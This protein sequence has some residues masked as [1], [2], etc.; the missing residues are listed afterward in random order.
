MIIRPKLHWLSFVFVW[1]GSVLRNI[2][3]RL[4]LNLVLSVVAVLCMPQFVAWGLHMSTAPFSL[5]GI[6]LAIFLGFRNNAS[7][8]RFWEARKLWGML[9]VSSRCL[10]RQAQ[11]L[12]GRE[13]GDPAVRE[14]TSLLIALAY[15]LKHQLRHTSPDATLARWVPPVLAQRLSTAQYPCVLLLREMGRWVQAQ[16]QVGRL[17]DIRMQAMDATLNELT[18]Y[19]GGCERIASTPIPYAYS[20]LLHRTVYVYCTLLPFS[21]LDAVGVLTPLISVFISYA[22]IALD[23]IASE[24][25]E[26]FGTEPNDLALDAM[27]VTFE[28]TLL[29]MNDVAELPPAMVP[30]ERYVLT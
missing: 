21:L 1:N 6:A 15:M 2:L 29:E 8:D 12:T 5:I 24:L 28:R 3:V 16:H 10:L 13:P 27:C 26:P 7:Y 17:T 11:T 30:N 20:L 25:E 4:L 22:F 18:T 9:L 14:L 23:A 19:H